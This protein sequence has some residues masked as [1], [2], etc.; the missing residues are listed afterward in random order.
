MGDSNPHQNLVHLN[1]FSGLWD[2]RSQV[3]AKHANASPNKSWGRAVGLYDWM[4]LLLTVGN[5][6]KTHKT[7]WEW[8]C[9]F[10]FWD[11]LHDL[12]QTWGMIYDMKCVIRDMPESIWTNRNMIH[13]CIYIYIHNLSICDIGQ[14]NVWL[15]YNRIYNKWNQV[16]YIAYNY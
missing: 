8:R 7:T 15:T 1:A 3:H 2:N 5:C 13:V 4:K 11:V 9:L 10:Q 14:Y 16:T 6:E 12:M